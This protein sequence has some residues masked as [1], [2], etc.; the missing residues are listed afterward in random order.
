MAFMEVCFDWI[1]QGFS[2]IIALIYFQAKRGWIDTCTQTSTDTGRSW[3]KKMLV[4]F[5]KSVTRTGCL[6][7]VGHNKSK[8][9]CQLG[10]ENVV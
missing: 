5:A 6:P 3:G 1:S 7:L 9:I 2:V 4:Q 8:E 10:M